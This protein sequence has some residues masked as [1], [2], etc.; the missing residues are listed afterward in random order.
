MY[1]VSGHSTSWQGHLVLR[2]SQNLQT[3]KH[4]QPYTIEIVRAHARD[5]TMAAAGHAG[6]RLV[7][8]YMQVFN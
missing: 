7:L 4:G 5:L 3:S 6:L 8:F 1:K 2:D